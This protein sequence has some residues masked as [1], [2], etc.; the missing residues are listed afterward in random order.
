MTFEL[1]PHPSPTPEDR[2][3]EILKEPGFGTTYTDHTAVVDWRA[4]G[5]WQNHRVEAYGNLELSPAAAVL[6][7]AETIFE[8]LKAY[9][10]DDGSVY[11]FRPDQNALRFQRSAARMA[12]PELPVS[13]FVESLE[14]LVAEDKAWVP[15]GRGSHCTCGRSCSPMSRSWVSAQPRPSATG[16]SHLRPGTSLG[17]SCARCASGS[18]GTTCALPR[19]D[20]CGEDRRQLCRFAGRAE[21]GHRQGLRPGALPRPS[22]RECGGGAGRHER[23]PRAQRRHAD[24]T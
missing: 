17:A 10:H 18:R 23:L 3:V 5:E 15:T 21:A 4:D 12:L 14:Q 19:R 22:P 9:K 20:R 24:H 11:T 16:S 1:V 13:T 6:H 8:G 7:Y 2:I